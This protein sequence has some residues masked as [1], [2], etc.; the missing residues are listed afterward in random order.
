MLRARGVGTRNI[1]AFGRTG[2]VRVS[3]SHA[4]RVA[5]SLLR[6]DNAVALALCDTPDRLDAPTVNAQRL[7][8]V[9][10]LDAVSNKLCLLVRFSHIPKS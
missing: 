10:R 8:G 4:P 6:G 9:Y 7:L 2:G 3:A 1:A 5:F